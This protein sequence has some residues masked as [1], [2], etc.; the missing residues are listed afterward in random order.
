M[1]YF[2][3]RIL[4]KRKFLLKII[5]LL[6][7]ISL[8]SMVFIFPS[9]LSTPHVLSKYFKNYVNNGV[10]T[11]DEG[12]YNFEEE[13]DGPMFD[14]VMDHGRASSTQFVED[15]SQILNES[16]IN[17]FS[18]FE[19]ISFSL[20][21][22]EYIGVNNFTENKGR[23]VLG[24]NTNQYNEINLLTNEST[25]GGA[26]IFSY[27]NNVTLGSYNVSYYEQNASLAI[28]KY[29]L[30][31][32]FQQ[33]FPYLNEYL[34]HGSKGINL[35]QIIL[36]PIN[37]FVAFFE[38]LIESQFSLYLFEGYIK[39]SKYQ[40]EIIYWSINS[41]SLI[42]KFKED[43]IASIQSV[44]SSFITND[45]NDNL[46]LAQENAFIVNV[47]FSFIRAIQ[48]LIWILSCIIV[49]FAIAKMQRSN[50]EKE[51]RTIFA[52]TSWLKRISSLTFESL[53]IT[54][55]SSA[56]AYLF[57]WPLIKMQ[58]LFGISLSFDRSV[59]LGISIYPAILFLLILIVNLDFEFHLRRLI[60][61]GLSSEEYKPFSL[62]PIYFKLL[63]IILILLL[64]YIL[65]K[66]FISLLY[67]IGIFLIAALI[68]GILFLLIR[69]FLRVV[70]SLVH[71]QKRRRDKPLTKFHLLYN[72][73]KKPLFT[74][75]FVYSFIFL[76]IS[77]L[78]LYSAT[79]SEFFRSDYK[80]MQAGEINIYTNNLSNTTQV[81]TFLQNNSEIIDYTTILRA[82]G[83][84]SNDLLPDF[85]YSNIYGINESDYFEFFKL[86]NKKNWLS[87]GQIEN[88]DNES[89]FVSTKFKDVGYNLGDLVQL[90]NN[91]TFT[92][93]GYVNNWPGISD[94][95]ST[96]RIFIVILD[97]QS[98]HIALESLGEESYSFNFKVHVS[99]ENIIA[100]V[101][102]LL[103]HLNSME[104]F[105]ELI[106][107]DPYVF[108]GIKIVF[109]FPIILLF[110]VLSILIVS[111]FIYTNLDD[112]HKSLE[113]KTLG[114]ILMVTDFRKPMF[115]YKLL[116]F[117]II[118]G[119][120]LTF[121]L[122]IFTASALILPILADI[123]L[124]EIDFSSKTILYSIILF[125]LYPALLLLQNLFEYINIKRIKLHLLYR[126]PE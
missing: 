62:I 32:D 22:Y 111:L 105:H 20:M 4:E 49:V 42:N 27:D 108:E 123:P 5:L 35:T 103:G 86:W 82:S 87:E 29:I 30:A 95:I 106:A 40:Q 54:T 96:E 50:V 47:V 1:G 113:A 115:W 73:W 26:I 56:F 9:Q 13:S 84:L 63:S 77:S 64:V 102:Y 45:F 36:L 16:S 83:N 14:F 89:I 85:A 53:L 24:L 79:T 125:T 38:P 11:I 52:G 8:S 114:L 107:L 58:L 76:V 126:H 88:F 39:F 119:F 124:S 10:I 80:Y 70:T 90:S 33:N 7:L 99:E 78:F 23:R 112:I 28:S 74:K 12:Y 65:N 44:E 71:R 67:Q 17:T 60:K 2:L 55:G 118:I 120:S 18:L 98:L 121:F 19:P 3:Y 117:S 34:V 66:T 46:N 122:L 41:V 69:L 100:T 104:S 68:C 59:I 81:D 72:L 61:N 93:R 75:I 6:G 92:I 94:F 57:I 21:S 101:D 109:I 91:Q 15:F 97:N 37:D 48:L 25:P 31:E 43:I 110:E 116:E 51:V